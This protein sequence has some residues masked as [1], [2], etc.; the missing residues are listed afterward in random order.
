VLYFSSLSEFLECCYEDEKTN[1]MLDSI[2]AFASVANDPRIS[3]I[4]LILFLNKVDL[5]KKRIEKFDL[6]WLFPSLPIEL[7]TS[8]G[9]DRTTDEFVM[10]N[11]LFIADQYLQSIQDVNRRE[12]VRNNL[13]IGSM[14]DERDFKRVTDACVQIFGSLEDNTLL[15]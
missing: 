8:S 11:I 15:N 7:R 6:S 13:Q 1:R 5:F 12:W 14:V 9:V 4:P 2:D 3:H 10:Q